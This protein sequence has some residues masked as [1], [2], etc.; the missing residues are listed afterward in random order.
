MQ[1][2]TKSTMLMWPD[3]NSHTKKADADIK[4]IA[5]VGSNVSWGMRAATIKKTP[6]RNQATLISLW[7]QGFLSLIH[8]R[9]LCRSSSSFTRPSRPSIYFSVRFVCDNLIAGQRALSKCERWR[10]VT[11]AICLVVLPVILV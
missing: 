2:S 6:M 1:Y 9:R 5:S 7:Q 3:L 8:S 11:E 4:I 10:G